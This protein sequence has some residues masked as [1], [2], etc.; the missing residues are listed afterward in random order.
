M[1]CLPVRD[2][3][4][5]TSPGYMRHGMD[6]VL[7]AAAAG[8]EAGER[9]GRKVGSKMGSA[10]LLAFTYKSAFLILDP[11]WG[12]RMLFKCIKTDGRG[13]DCSSIPYLFYLVA[14]LVS[15]GN[16]GKPV[17]SVCRRFPRNLS[18]TFILR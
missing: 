6:P 17:N 10:S 5:L 7:F 12:G 13:G 14:V 16:S 9:G 11:A 18:K 3:I 2:V 15:M 1:K 8:A 4:H